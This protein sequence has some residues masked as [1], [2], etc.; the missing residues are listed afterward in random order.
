M[1]YTYTV[2]FAVTT[3]F[4]TE[5]Q[6]VKTINMANKILMGN[7][8]PLHVCHYFFDEQRS[9]DVRASWKHSLTRAHSGSVQR[10]AH[11]RMRH[12]REHSELCR[13]L[14]AGGCATKDRVFA[15]VE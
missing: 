5:Q 12:V 2:L 3:S 8:L 9:P 6:D 14:D 11:A 4:H 15:A 7:I 13:L 1:C 10:T